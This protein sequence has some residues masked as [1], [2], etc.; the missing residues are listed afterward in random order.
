LPQRLLDAPVS[1]L[2][3]GELKKWRD[4][5]GRTLERSTVNR[6][7]TV[8][9]AA[10]NL[11][12]KTDERIRNR[13]AWEIGLEPL[14]N[15]NEPRDDVILDEDRI[16]KLIAAARAESDE[17]GLFVETAAVTGAR[18]SQLARLDA[19]DVQD[20]PA[21][22]LMPAS[23]KGDAK[24]KAS[25]YPLPITAGLARRLRAA[26][27]GKPPASA[28]LVK[29]I[30]QPAGRPNGGRD[31]IIWT[32][33]RIA[34]AEALAAPDADGNTRSHS[35]IAAILGV[36]KNTITGLFYRRRQAKP[37]RPPRLLRRGTER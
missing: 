31:E 8:L 12:A 30:Q 32:A 23:K 10:L 37:L 1:R 17:F 34:E 24:R 33:E 20:G 27:A 14:P 2:R 11:A 9:K 21:P 29:P 6:T 5:L 15:A 19:V 26:A 35:E 36:S 28:L 3:P 25:R 22:R 4:G 16:R 13:S 18:P 7:T